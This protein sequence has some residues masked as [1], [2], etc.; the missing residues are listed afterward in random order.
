MSS[1][2]YDVIVNGAA[3]FTGRLVCAYLAQHAPK[4]LRWAAAARNVPKAR[5]AILSALEE[6]L[7]RSAALA[8]RDQ[9]TVLECD[10][11]DT[12]AALRLAQQT[13]LMLSL[14]GPYHRLGKSLVGSCI[15]A[16]ADYVD[17]NGEPLYMREIID[18]YDAEAKRAGV[19]VVLSAGFDSTPFDL[20]CLFAAS[21]LR[22][23]RADAALGIRRVHSLV[24]MMGSFSGGTVASGLEGDQRGGEAALADPFLLG[25]APPGG[26]RPEDAPHPQEPRWDP[27]A[28]EG[29][30]GW[31][32]PFPMGFITSKVV[33]RTNG[34]LPRDLAYGA[35]FACAGAHLLRTR[36]AWLTGLA[37]SL[38]STARGWLFGLTRV[39]YSE[40][41]DLGE[42]K[43]LAFKMIKSA[44]APVAVRERLIREGRLPKPGEGPSAETRASS[45]F[46]VR[47]RATAEDG[48]SLRALVGG[49]DPGYDETAKMVA[50]AALCLG[51]LRPPEAR[52]A[53]PVAA[54]VLTPAAACGMSLVRRLQAAGMTFKVDEDGAAGAAP[55]PSRL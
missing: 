42:M 4:S 55:A 13:S 22:C 34:L 12:S 31:T 47:V 39:R 28:A 44:A 53:A 6:K 49:G 9:I 5:D 17:I 10:S 41:S 26:P 25:G 8:A 38:P 18:E 54:G 37:R 11:T 30:G 29:A 20:G 15:A 43:E 2:A 40:A 19:R 50:E 45:W 52:R 27:E 36:A 3:G 32:T 7:D 16:G 46:E 33:R 1:R 51:E 14:V 48:S 24:R 21:E 23:R 35:D